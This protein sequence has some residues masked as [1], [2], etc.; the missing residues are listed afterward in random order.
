MRARSRGR[1][2]MMMMMVMTMDNCAAYYGC[3]YAQS[4][5]ALRGQV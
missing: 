5:C 2:R 4:Y 3:A 1:P